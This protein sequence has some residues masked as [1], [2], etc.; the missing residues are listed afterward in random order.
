M[1][2]QLKFYFE[3][4][5][6]LFTALLVPLLVFL[7]FWQIDRGVEKVQLATSFKH[8][9]L[10]SPAPLTIGLGQTSRESLAYLPV[11]LVGQF[12]EQYF[13]LDNRMQ[14][15]KYGNEVL[16]ILELATGGVALVNRGWVQADS[17]RL[18]LPAVESVAGEVAITGHVYVPPGEPYLLADQGL[19]PGWPKRV[20]AVEMDKIT[21]AIDTPHGVFPYTV[22][23]DAGQRGALG[24]NWQ[25]INVSP[26]KHHGYAVQWFAMAGALALLYLLRSTNLW[27]IIR[28]KPKLQAK[29]Q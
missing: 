17:S 23:L 1:S 29:D 13:L 14:D 5:I 16:G 25:I 21:A 8:Q 10:R 11:R 7:G 3:W 28:R 4:R 9:Q 24:V 19:A 26:A 2:K 27:Q 6:T 15:R 18:T 20:Q 12:R 22:R